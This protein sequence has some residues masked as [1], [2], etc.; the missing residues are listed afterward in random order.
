MIAECRVAGSSQE[1][2][3]SVLGIS[4][5]TLQRWALNPGQEDLRQG[6]KT[7]PAHALTE[8][9]RVRILAIS[10]S[11]EFQDKSP[12]QIV[13]ALADRGEYVASEASFY[14]VLKANNLL[15]HR[16]RSKPRTVGRPKAY[17]ATKPRQLFS[18]DITYLKSN[19]QGKYF[20]LYMFLDVFSRKIVGWEVHESESPDYSSILLRKICESEGIQRDHL[21]VHAD[22]GGPMKGA[23]ML[24]TMQK[25][26]I[27][28]SFSRPSVSNDN[29]FSEALFK[30]LKYCPQYPSQPFLSIDSA[31]QW[32]SAFVGWYNEEHMH[33]AISFTTPQSR[34][35]GSDE[36]ILAKRHEVYR[37]AQENKPSRWSAK[38]RSWEKVAVVRLNWLKDDSA[39]DRNANIL[40][41][42]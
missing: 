39:C 30:T 34:H 31:R 18:W 28:P 10:N 6:P 1:S 12:H 17:E 35:S 3:C 4:E 21:S 24:V 14:R 15:A 19:I 22:N 42:S 7:L 9:E 38:T 41:V 20:F 29:P 11:K 13:P 8:D 32:V 27:M 25:L 40:S 16:G 26:G 33:S 2:A 5:R 37:K 23:T 36:A